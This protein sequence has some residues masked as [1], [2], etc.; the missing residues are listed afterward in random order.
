MRTRTTC[1]RRIVFGAVAAGL[2]GAVVAGP[3]AA[4]APAACTASGLA[5][6]AS[7]AL[8]AAGQ[9]LGSHPDADNV[10]TAA[11][12]QSPEDARSSVRGYFTA[13]PNEFLELQ[14]ILRP[15]TDLRNQCDVP[16]SPGQL[17]LLIDTLS[18]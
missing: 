8:G 4:A 15:V 9:Y 7:G 5:T 10:L 12:S 3:P 11:A 16:L 1:P 18:D 17:A 13:H 6:T 2:L 14:N